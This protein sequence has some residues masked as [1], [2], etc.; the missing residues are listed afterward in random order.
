MSEHHSY[1]NKAK[2]G[3]NHDIQQ[4]PFF[5]E[6]KILSAG[7]PFGQEE[8]CNSFDEYKSAFIEKWK[9]N[10][11]RQSVHYLFENLQKGDYVWILNNGI[12]YVA[13]IPNNPKDS[14][15]YTNSKEF[16]K[17]H[18]SAHIKNIDWIPV[19]TEEAVPGSVSTAKG[20]LRGAFQRIDKNELIGDDGYTPTSLIA[21]RVISEKACIHTLNKQA[22]NKQEIFDLMGP[23]ALEDL[24]GMWLFVKEGYVIIPS[25][26]KIGTQKYEYVMVD[27][28]GKSNKKIYIQTK[29]GDINLN[30]NDY[31][32]L[33]SIN[34]QNEVWLLTTKGKIN[35]DSKL[36]FLKFS[37]KKEKIVQH[38]LNEL[39]EFIF[40]QQNRNIL[41]QTITNWL[42]IFKWV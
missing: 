18:A 17:N 25:T 2:A 19:G 38:E 9:I 36:K 22:L 41:P 37:G 42:D 1:F 11:N 21:K 27:G 34:S 35:G 7:W 14:F 40:D 23:T 28:S 31:Q 10:W 30:T 33:V 13:Q 39:I 3:E 20:R 26:N 29:N 15:Q 5:I 12:Y 8:R 32:N 6:N 16:V 4:A 24:L